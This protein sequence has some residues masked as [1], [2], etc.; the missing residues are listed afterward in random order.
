[1]TLHNYDIKD[2]S[3]AEAGRQ[4]IEW[5]FREMPV[6]GLIR[7]RFAKEQPLK[8]VRISACL[9]VTTETANLALTLKAGGADLIL[10]AS[11][12]LSTQDDAA[13]ALVEYDIP[14]NAMKGEDETTYYRHLNTAIDHKP[15]LTVDDGAD[16]VT[17]L[18]TKRQ[19][20]MDNVIGGTEETTTGVVRLRSMAAAGKLRYPIISVND[21]QTKYLFDNRYGTG[22]STIDGITR[23]TNILWAGKKVVVCGY[24]WC[25]HGVALRAKGLGAHVIVVEVAPVRALEAVMDGFQVMPLMEAARIGDIFVTT[26]GNKS[27]IDQAHFE[28]MKD[29]AILANSGHFNVEINIPSLESMAKRTRKIRDFVDEYSLTNGRCLYLL[30]E[31]RLINLA[32]AEGHPASVMDMSFA[33]QALC[34][35]YLARNAGKLKATVH[36][37]PEDIDR[38]V[39]RLKLSAMGVSIDSLTGEQK[40][41]LASWEEGT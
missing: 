40:K 12:P 16:L 11:N 23:A 34:L 17:T 36:P 5:A 30:G 41:Y 20:M 8:G 39:A 14:T 24:G 9:H 27:V 3:L 1:M 18:H 25:G 13:A 37:V 38:Q 22:Q 4:H 31:G 28:V 33:N 32:A 2:Q 6:V 7:E 15:Q 29:G 35:E 21:A 19:E 26:T 10:C